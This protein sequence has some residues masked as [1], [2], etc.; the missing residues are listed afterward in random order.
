M[1]KN[2]YLP[3]GYHI[4]NGAL[5][6]HE[7]EGNAVRHIYA[8]Y[9]S[10]M[11]YRA[12][13]EKMSAS[14]IRYKEDSTD[15]NKHMI[16][17]ILENPRYCGA[18]NFPAIIPASVSGAVAALVGQK[19]QVERVSDALDSIRRKAICGA[20]GAKYTRDGR[21]S[22]YEAWC[23][24]AEGRITPKR[25]S[26]QA[27]L[28]GVTAALNALIAEPN[29][30]ELS[31]KHP[32]EYSLDVT[33]LGN[34]INRELEKAEVDSDYLK[35]LIFS[36]AAAKYETCNEQETAYLTRQLLAI[37]TAQQPLESFSPQL[38]EDTVKQVVIDPDGGIHLRMKN[39][40]LIYNANGKE[41]QPCKYKQ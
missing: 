21:N 6:I 20:C 22:K 7:T 24:A 35:L 12:I 26:D 2:R 40:K 41:Q 3:F 4:Q 16:K 17:R 37:F 8:D 32:Y 28:D 33:R 19:T 10:G 9:Q 11:S 34:Q 31:S 18:D 29:K 27:L 23:C 39:E 5:C 15:W 38:F 13:A 36:H 14:G 30:L 25:I 1:K